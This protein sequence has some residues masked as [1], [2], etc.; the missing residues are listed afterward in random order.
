MAE[1]II[2]ATL[3]GENANAYVALAAA[4]AYFADTLEGREWLGFGREDRARALLSATRKIDEEFRYYGRP[5]DTVT[6]Q[7]LKF[8]RDGDY[9]SSGAL[10]IPDGIRYATC[11]LA[12]HLLCAEKQPDLLDR[13]RLQE[14]GVRRLS[15][16]GVAEQYRPGVWDNIPRR[17]RKL[18]RPFIDAG[19]R[20]VVE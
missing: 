2:D 4:D 6:P 20:T 8:P 7:A 3:A 13:E 11:E 9:D 19:G 15:V 12:L 18:L 10:R 5:H 14:Q 17:V 16:D 1:P